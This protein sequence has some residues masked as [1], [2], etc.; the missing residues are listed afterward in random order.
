MALERWHGARVTRPPVDA[1]GLIDPD[2]VA[3][4]LAR[5]TRSPGPGVVT[6]MLGNNE[7]GAIRPVTQIAAAAHAH[8]AVLHV[9]AAQAAGK[10]SIEVAVLGADL[11][12]VVGHKM[13]APKGIAASYVRSGPPRSGPVTCCS[14][15][16]PTAPSPPPATSASCC[17]QAS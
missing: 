4:V 14:S 15:P 8:G 3:D 6:V 12:T 7:T 16:A 1:C 10:T 13:Y 9:D 5:P 17:A 2:A 11:L